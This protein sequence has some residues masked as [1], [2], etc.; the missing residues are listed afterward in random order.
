MG[1]ENEGKEGLFSGVVAVSFREGI[2]LGGIF[3]PPKNVC[4]GV[5]NIRYAQFLMSIVK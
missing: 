1:L 3:S 4:G 5:R 2:F